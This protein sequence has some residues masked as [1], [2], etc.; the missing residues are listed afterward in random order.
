MRPRIFITQ[1]VARTAIERLAAVAEV[2]L[3]P[4]PLRIMDN[5]ALCEAV[6]N[7][8]ILF[9]LLHDK[10]DHRV[11]A[12]NPGLRVL[13]PLLACLRDGELAGDMHSG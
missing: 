5:D 13:Q 4:D 9:C 1:P 2:D 8:D 11:I 3:N 7:A 10:V 12:T 6:A